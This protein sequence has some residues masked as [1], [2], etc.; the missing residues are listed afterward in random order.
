MGVENYL[1][2]GVLYV[3]FFHTSVGDKIKNAFI[4]FEIELSKKK[5]KEFTG[6]DI[7]TQQSLPRVKKIKIDES[8][9]NKLKQ[10][11]KSN[12]ILLQRLHFIGKNITLQEAK[13]IL[14]INSTNTTIDFVNDHSNSIFH[15]NDIFTNINVIVFVNI[16]RNDVAVY[17]II[18]YTI[19]IGNSFTSMTLDCF[20]SEFDFNDLLE[21]HYTRCV[22]ARRI[23]R[24]VLNNWIPKPICND[25]KIGILCKIGWSDIETLNKQVST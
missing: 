4:K 10:I 15:I 23:T 21:Y 2:I 6:Q 9:N 16:N 25:G 19:G 17:K 20:W 7:Y 13:N 24:H 11:I 1:Y 22:A 5:Y 18:P 3:V 12:K 8:C 14:L